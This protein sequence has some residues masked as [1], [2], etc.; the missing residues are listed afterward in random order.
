MWVYIYDIYVNPIAEQHT[1]HQTFSNPSLLVAFCKL[2]FLRHIISFRNLFGSDW[3]IF[4]LNRLLLALHPL[5][6]CLLLFLLWVLVSPD[7]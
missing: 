6:S 5:N 3:L 2:I 1:V 4:S 7:T